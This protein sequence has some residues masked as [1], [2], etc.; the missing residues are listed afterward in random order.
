MGKSKKAFIVFNPLAGTADQPLLVRYLRKYFPS[1]KWDWKL[2]VIRFPSSTKRLELRDKDDLYPRDED[3]AALT[4]LSED[5]PDSALMRHLRKVQKRNYDYIFVAGG[6]GTVSWVLNGL[7]GSSIPVG[8]IPLGTGNAIAQELGIP[9]NVK[10]SLQLLRSADTLPRREMDLI[11]VGS[12]Y[13]VLHVDIGLGAITVSRAKAS[14]KAKKRLGPVA[15]FW[16]A[17]ASLFKHQL[18]TFR[19]V[20][21]DKFTCRIRASEI[22]ICNCASVGIA[23]GYTWGDNIRPDDGVLDVA[24]FRLR[25]L[26]HYAKLLYDIIRKRASDNP[27]VT[28]L[29]AKKS[30]LVEVEDSEEEEM[31]VEGDGEVFGTTPVYAEIQ[32]K[33]VV[34]LSAHL[35]GGYEGSLL[36]EKLTIKFGRDP[37]LRSRVL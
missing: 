20:I 6:D 26:P 12:Q 10:R 24:I 1:P 22:V 37:R 18:C 15:Y 25:S 34:M 35:R 33:A 19:V 11:R 27:H 30:V 17:F 28:Y 3:D 31:K 5:D 13:F 8:V 2:Y 29:R 4:R 21:D 23:P 32:P 7:V 16:N 14:K 36:Q 9:R